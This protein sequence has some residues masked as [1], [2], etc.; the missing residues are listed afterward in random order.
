MSPESKVA[1]EHAT[2]VK[3]PSVIRYAAP[4]NPAPIPATGPPIKPATMG[5]VS[6]IFRGA[7]RISIPLIDP[8]TETM[9]NTRIRSTWFFHVS[10]PSRTSW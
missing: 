1:T 4:I 10:I 2:I 9:P 6:R 5:P 8:Y 3:P 7:P